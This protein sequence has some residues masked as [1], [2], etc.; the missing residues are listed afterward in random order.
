MIMRHSHTNTHALTK[1]H[2]DT[3]TQTHHIFINREDADKNE[4]VLK[5]K[6]MIFLHE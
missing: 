5:S 1:T 6:I 2:S 3:Q 4:E